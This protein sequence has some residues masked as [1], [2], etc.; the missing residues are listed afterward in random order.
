MQQ[1]CATRLPALG[2]GRFR[3]ADNLDYSIEALSLPLADDGC[4][5]DVILVGQY[6]HR[7]SESPLPMR[8]NIAEPA[9]LRPWLQSDQLRAFYDL[10]FDIAAKRRPRREDFPPERLLPW[11]GRV[12]LVERDASAARLRYRL[13]GTAQAALR[14]R[15]PT[16]Q[17]VQGNYMGAHLG[18]PG[19]DVMLNYRIVIEKRT[20][21][22][23]YNPII[24]AMP[25]GSSMRQM[26]WHA[27][28]SVLMPLSSD[29]DNV[30]MVFCFSDLDKDGLH[31]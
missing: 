26:P 6:D 20:V 10:W 19:D 25:D 8:C 3:Q 18:I 28:S 22:Y 17:P 24:G 29:G 16:G 1:V 15:D 13:V 11:L 30:D 14:G 23:T 7:V 27:S 31:P 2:I 12:L 5:P 9:L 4:H 21:V